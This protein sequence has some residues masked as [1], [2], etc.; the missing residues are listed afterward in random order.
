MG[1]VA[2]LADGTILD[3]TTEVVLPTAGFAGAV[4]G[5]VARVLGVLA[6]YLAS[7]SS[8]VKLSFPDSISCR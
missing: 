3:P 7:I 8:R 5:T 1:C 4:T 2:G 6:S